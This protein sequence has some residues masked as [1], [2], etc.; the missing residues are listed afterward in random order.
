[1][2]LITR[3]PACQ[4]L[5]KVVPDQLRI[6][7]GWV[8]CGQCNEVFD[9]SSLLLSPATAVMNFSQGA[10]APIRPSAELADSVPSV[11]EP[12]SAP[13]NEVITR[14]PATGE[15]PIQIEPND[16]GEPDRKGPTGF[17]EPSFLHTQQNTS[18]WRKVLTRILLAVLGLALLL[19][20]AGQIVFHERNQIV[21]RGPGLKGLL[22]TLCRPLS[23]GLSALQQKDA[24]VIDGASFTKIKRDAYRLNF[25]LR[26]TAA[27]AVAA[28]AVELTLTDS[29]DQPV[30]RRIFAATEF[31][32]QSDTLA[33]TSE[34]SASI[35]LAVTTAGT[36]ERIVGYRLLAF[37]P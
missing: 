26:N 24:V 5:F 27:T 12:V 16:L 11:P 6:S 9:A 8:R 18:T 30:V 35:A 37:Y 31:G 3:C 13:V 28:P 1:M 22:L 20:L 34:W 19:G 33:A 15:N 14:Q 7:E 17:C 23:C 25:T 4:T 10:L 32:L 2:S 21:A 29:L 36:A